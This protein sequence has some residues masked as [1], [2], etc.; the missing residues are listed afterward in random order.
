MELLVDSNKTKIK[1]DFKG[2]TND[3]RFTAILENKEYAI[4]PTHKEYRK[5]AEGEFIKTYKE[6]KEA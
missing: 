3:S 5:V 4:D 1:Q 2:N 6:I